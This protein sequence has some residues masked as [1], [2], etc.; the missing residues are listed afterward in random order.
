MA[1]RHA[2]VGRPCTLARFATDRKRSIVP[3][4]VPTG[5]VRIK[6]A[7]PGATGEFMYCTGLKL[8]PERRR[9]LTWFERET[10]PPTGPR[11]GELWDIQPTMTGHYTIK[12]AWPGATGELMYC[13]GSKLNEELRHVLTWIGGENPPTGPP[14][15]ELWDIQPVDADAS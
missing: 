9:V 11:G 12:S 10:L 2:P 6:S 1:I 8:N 14:G 3:I 4:A 5:V 15:G 7:W 13:G